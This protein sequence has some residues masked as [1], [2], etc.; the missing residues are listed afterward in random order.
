MKLF[1]PAS[2]AALVTGSTTG[3]GRA[4]AVG[5]EAAGAGIVFHGETPRPADLPADSAYVQS[6]L[7]DPAAPEALIA[8]AVAAK[9]AL[10]LLVCNA[11]MPSDGP[12][13]EMT[14]GQWDRTMQLNVRATY[15]VAQS[16]ARALVA[17]KRPGAIV[18]VSST[19]GFQPEEG[20]TV[21]DTSK[22]ALI[23][24][25]GRSPRRWHPMRFV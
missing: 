5:L 24:L 8:A 7:F 14:A 19:N 2:D 6:D 11:G 21:Y 17:R 18:I 25:S 9:P 23:N 4:I 13:L 20:C 12:F 15:F 10:N 22:G 16:F 1:S 3:I